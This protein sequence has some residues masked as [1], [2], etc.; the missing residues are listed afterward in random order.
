MRKGIGR[1]EEGERREMEGV[2]RR[3]LG[4]H[5]LEERWRR[6]KPKYIT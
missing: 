3:S 5:N 2:K 1:K 4:Q 6:R